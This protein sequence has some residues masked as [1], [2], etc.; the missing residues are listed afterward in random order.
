MDLYIDSGGDE[1]GGARGG[2]AGDQTGNEWT[3]RAWYNRPWDCVLRYPDTAVG[4]RIA[5]LGCEAAL[6]D[7]IGYDQNE[8]Y[9]Y[10]QLL[11]KAGYHPSKIT[12]ACEADCSAGWLLN[13]Y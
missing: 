4:Q 8:R 13:E 9:T 7:K 10:W 5:E 1:K 6:N 2:K 12:T 3:L 11:Q